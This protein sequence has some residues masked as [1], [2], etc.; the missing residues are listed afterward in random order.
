[1]VLLGFLCSLRQPENTAPENFDH[2]SGGGIPIPPE[3]GLG[4]K[5]CGF[6]GGRDAMLIRGLE[7]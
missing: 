1:M 2:P 3:G 6:C 4:E 7:R 5:W